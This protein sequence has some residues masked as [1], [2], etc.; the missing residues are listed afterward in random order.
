MEATAR[1]YDRTGSPEEARRHMQ[2][3]LDLFADLRQAGAALLP[4]GTVEDCIPPTYCSSLEWEQ[5]QSYRTLR[6]A[7]VSCC[8]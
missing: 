3:A 4:P 2:A 5:S 6:R 8:G 7:P 1:R